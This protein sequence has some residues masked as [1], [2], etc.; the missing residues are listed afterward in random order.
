MC[1][2]PPRLRRG[3]VPAGASATAGMG[4]AR[5]L[6]PH[7]PARQPHARKPTPASRRAITGLRSSRRPRARGLREVSRARPLRASLPFARDLGTRL[8]TPVQ[9]AGLATGAVRLRARNCTLRNLLWPFPEHLRETHRVD[10]TLP[11]EAPRFARA[12]PLATSRTWS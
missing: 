10:P 9:S 2:P 3:S 5:P 12:D 7:P 6:P 11:D 8:R 1:L 4:G